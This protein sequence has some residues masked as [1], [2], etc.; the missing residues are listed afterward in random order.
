M[1]RTQPSPLRTGSSDLE[2]LDGEREA[3]HVVSHLSSGPPRD[4]ILS[5][6]GVTV[7]FGGVTA[8]NDVRLWC[9]EGKITAL[10]GPNGAGK[11]TCFN[12]ICGEQRPTAG[13]ITF[14]GEDVT[15]SPIHERARLGMGRTFQNLAVM[16]ELS[17]LDNVRVGASRFADYGPIAAMLG[18]RRVSRSDR[19]MTEIAYRALECVG[20]TELA[21]TEA[22]ALPYGDL[23]R[24]ELA[25]ALCLG[26]KLLLLDEPAAGLDSAEGA[27]LA[28]ALRGIRDHWGTSILIVEHDLELVRS[29]ADEVFVLDFG[30]VLAGGPTAEVLNDPLVIEAYVGKPAGELA[31]EEGF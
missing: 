7:Q 11:T 22:S 1:S 26:P 9:R 21:Q 29:L 13:T 30:V 23:R 10:I 6:D 27:D 12:V 19:T 20:L 8:N 2:H 14:L 16:G 17:V 5:I 25:R 4:A 18:L 3:G 28:A 31:K 24:V 15:H